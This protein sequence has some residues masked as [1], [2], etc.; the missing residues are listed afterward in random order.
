MIIGCLHCG[1][2]EVEDVS[3]PY[4][5]QECPECGGKSAMT[6]VLAVDLLN[7]CFRE[8]TEAGAYDAESD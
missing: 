4:M 7:K 1:E 2:V 3:Y 5:W 8:H 6:M